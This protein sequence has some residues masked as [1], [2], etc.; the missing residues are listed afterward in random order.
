MSFE[1]VIETYGYWALFWPLRY[2][3]LFYGPFILSG[4]KNLNNKVCAA[5]Q[6]NNNTRIA[7]N[8]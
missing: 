7:D 5:V 8:V 4:R 3:D 2:V 1:N 6:S